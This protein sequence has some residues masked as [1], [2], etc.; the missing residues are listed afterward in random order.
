MAEVQ[1]DVVHSFAMHLSCFPI[2]NTMK[3]YPNVKWVYS[4]WGSDLFFYKDNE[5]E[6]KKIKD[7]NF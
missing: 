1:P 6:A 7:V 3:K 5:M 4:S 2:Y